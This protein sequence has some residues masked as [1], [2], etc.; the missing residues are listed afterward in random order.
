MRRGRR[1]ERSGTPA[2]LLVVGLGNPGEEYAHT[3]HNVGADV[4]QVLAARHGGSL[5]RSKDRA[6]ACEVRIGDARVAL[7]IPT[8]FMNVSGEAVKPLVRRYGVS[9]EHLVV[10]VDDLDLPVAKLRLR[11]GGGTGGHRGLA[12]IVQTLHDDEFTRV[13]IGIGRPPGTQDPADYVLRRFGKSDR[14]AIDV[15]IEQAADA[16]ETI[17]SQGFEPAMNRHN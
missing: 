15:T 17:A 5:K 10:I 12:S 3:R 6:F 7:A 4:V 14:E 1:E 2:D 16:I 9:V 8:T 13:R 11:H